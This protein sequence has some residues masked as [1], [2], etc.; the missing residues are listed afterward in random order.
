MTSPRAGYT[1][2]VFACAAAIAALRWLQ[3]DLRR[4]NTVSLD[5]VNPAETVEIPIEQVARLGPHSA[6]GISRSDPGDNVDMTRNTPIWAIVERLSEQALGEKLTIRGGEGIGW[7]TAEERPAI[8]RYAQQVMEANLLPLLGEHDRI[9]V[10]IILPEGRSLAQRTSN[11]AF[12]VVE[13]LSLLGTSGLSQPLS[14]PDQLEAF[15][16]DV[17]SRP[18]RGCLVFCIG[19]NGLSLAQQMGVPATR[20]VKT[21]NWLGPLLVEAGMQ[22]VEQILLFGYHG[23]LMKLAG[24]IFHSH[25]HVAD[26]RREVLTAFCA[27]VGLSPENLQ[28]IFSCQTAEAGLAHLRSLDTA[29]G[30]CWVDRVYGA[31]A[32]EVDHRA[33]DYIRKHAER[34]VLVGSVLFGG[35]RQVIVV[36]KTGSAILTK[37][38]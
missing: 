6:L 37:F 26:G 10:T 2:P 36:S 23:K 14:A 22:G 28:K 9:T 16:E 21:A 7:I 25:H 12:G 8:Y 3:E 18:H 31:I 32:Q 35:D 24:G 19:E 30:S 34:T 27:Q 4:L 29:I 15:R 11:A 33:A 5:L 13:G 38:C 20:L 17:R 1:L